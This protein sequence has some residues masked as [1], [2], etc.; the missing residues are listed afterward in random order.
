[1]GGRLLLLVLSLIAAGFPLAVAW[2]CDR[3][4]QSVFHVAVLGIVALA[5]TL[6]DA[7][8]GQILAITSQVPFASNLPPSEAERLVHQTRMYHLRVLASWLLV[9][10]LGTLAGVVAVAM[11]AVRAGSVIFPRWLVAIGYLAV[12]TCLPFSIYFWCT[13]WKARKYADDA[14]LEEMRWTYDRTHPPTLPAPEHP[15][16][17]EE[18]HRS[19]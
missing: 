2:F 15:P 6:A 11:A 9:K 16:K 12:G 13:Y 18:D 4:L 17:A 10:T 7:L 1:M 8:H 5:V 3:S 19:D 14:R